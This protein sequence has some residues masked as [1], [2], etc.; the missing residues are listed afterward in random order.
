[1]T[2]VATAVAVDWSQAQMTQAAKNTRIE[3]DPKKQV[4][5]RRVVRVSRDRFAECWPLP[6]TELEQLAFSGADDVSPWLLAGIDVAPSGY[7]YLR[8]GL[9]NQERSLAGM[10]L[11]YSQGW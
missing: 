11:L 7:A 6:W 2:D 9:A 3:K 8:E 5:L 4:E 10:T 1:M